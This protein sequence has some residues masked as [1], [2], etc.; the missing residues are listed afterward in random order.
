VFSHTFTL[1]RDF[2][3]CS[4]VL[5]CAYQL[6]ESRQCAI[7][8]I[9]LPCTHLQG[10]AILPQLSVLLRCCPNVHKLDVTFAVNDEDMGHIVAL[11]GITQLCVAGFDRLRIDLSQKPSS[12]Q[13]LQIN[14]E[15]LD[16]ISLGCLPL[17]QLHE[18]FEWTSP[19]DLKVSDNR[20]DKLPSCMHTLISPQLCVSRSKTGEPHF[21][22]SHVLVPACV[23]V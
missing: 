20:I 4:N 13:Q 14:S 6:G 1:A 2:L 16:F 22:T 19:T 23:S 10:K 5:L 17:N 3:L 7:L 18:A 12:W 21:M 15:I 11:P 8:L 9:T